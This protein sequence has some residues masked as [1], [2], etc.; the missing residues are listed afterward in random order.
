MFLVAA[1][2]LKGEALKQQAQHTCMRAC[3]LHS[4]FGC[5]GLRTSGPCD[6]RGVA[7]LHGGAA[8]ALSRAGAALG[9]ALAGAALARAGA[10]LGAALAGALQERDC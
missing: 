1:R 5:D 2:D 6:L 7:L 8:L 4:W 3:T 9:A 10:A